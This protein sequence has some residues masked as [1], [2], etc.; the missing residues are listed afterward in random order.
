MLGVDLVKVLGK[1]AGQQ[2]GCPIAGNR[3]RCRIPEK[4][5]GVRVEQGNAI[6][7]LV[8]RRLKKFRE[9]FTVC[10]HRRDSA[11]RLKPLSAEL[12]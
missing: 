5:V 4:H 3:R 7:Q 10:R 11:F 6:F 12:E 1:P 2:I 9:H 8:Q